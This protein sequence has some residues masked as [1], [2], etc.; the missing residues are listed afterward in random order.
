MFIGRW[1]TLKFPDYRSRDKSY[2]SQINLTQTYWI[3]HTHNHI[4]T[5]IKEHLVNTLSASWLFVLLTTD[6]SWVHLWFLSLF[7]QMCPEFILLL[8]PVEFYIISKHELSSL[9]LGSNL[10]LPPHIPS[11]RWVLLIFVMTIKSMRKIICK[12]L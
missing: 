1:K 3:T 5:L 11:H 7:L 4:I 2:H 6:S 10:L 12:L 9:Y 8:Y